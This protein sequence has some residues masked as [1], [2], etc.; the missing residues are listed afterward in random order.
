MSTT[1]KNKSQPKNK[2]RKRKENIATI[3]DDPKPMSPQSITISNDPCGR[4]GVQLW[5]SNYGCAKTITPKLVRKGFV[6]DRFGSEN[7]N[8]FW[9]CK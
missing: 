7:G 4:N 6:M 2:T 1:V 9:R 8:F 3:P 5:P